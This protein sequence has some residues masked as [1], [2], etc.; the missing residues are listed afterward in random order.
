MRTGR[1]NYYMINIKAISAKDFR[2][3]ISPYVVVSMRRK[4]KA[5]VKG[6]A[7]L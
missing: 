3:L 1:G 6:W 4:L 7:M 2:D 5:E